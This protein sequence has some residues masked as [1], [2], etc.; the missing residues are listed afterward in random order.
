MKQII[1]S[2]GL[3]RAM[4]TLFC[5]I[6]ANNPNIGGGETSPLLEYLVSVRNAFSRTPEVQAALTEELV[7]DAYLNF[8]REGMQG[9]ASKITS[10]SIYID[11][12]RGWMHFSDFLH[13][14]IPDAKI[15][16][17]VRDLRGIVASLEKKR[18]EHAH[19]TD[20]RENIQGRDFVTMEHRV[21]SY[22]MD[23]PL[24]PALTRLYAAIQTGAIDKM[25]IIRAEDLCSKPKETMEGVYKY[26]N[27]PVFHADYTNI[28]QMTVENDRV[29]DYAI[30][31][32]HKIRGEIKPIIKDY[33][34]ILGKEICNQIKQGNQWFFDY[35]KYY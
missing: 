23:L 26:L 9:Y 22:L 33:E 11:K 27:I 21:N 4:T 5:N 3:P 25:L 28:Q 14:I 18:R 6:L 35:F 10:K 15:V 30:Y 12:S 31:G 17:L 19:I 24:N 20:G 32:D 34:Q 16:V 29:P 1:F 13:K 8:L 2:S 7:T